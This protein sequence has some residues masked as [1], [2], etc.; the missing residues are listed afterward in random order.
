MAAP[1]LR[2]DNQSDRVFVCDMRPGFTEDG[3]ECVLPRGTYDVILD[4]STGDG[5]RGFRMTLDGVSPDGVRDVGSVSVDMAQIGI[6]DRNTF[7][8]HFNGDFEELYD[9]SSFAVDT[10][11]DGAIK[12]SPDDDPDLN[13]L[14]VIVEWDG[15]YRVEQLVSGSRTVGLAVT[16]AEPEGDRALVSADSGDEEPRQWTRVTIK[17]VGIGDPLLFVDDLSCDALTLDE[18]L[19]DLTL[20]VELHLENHRVEF[21]EVKPNVELRHYMPKIRGFEPVK[22]HLDTE[23]RERA[24][25]ISLSESFDAAPL[26]AS[27]TLEDISKLVLAVTLHVR[28][29][30]DRP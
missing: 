19:D 24:K 4:E 1:V 17:R 12:I 15:I 21:D 2:F 9:W 30:T 6:F 5:G 18:V 10:D 3:I 25:Q 22:A 23:G 20:E 7:L 28:N 14:V 16:Y 11:A 27:A 26:P 8:E 13:A 29:S